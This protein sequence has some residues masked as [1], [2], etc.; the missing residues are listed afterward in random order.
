VT[1]VGFVTPDPTAVTRV[2][3][4]DLIAAP[5]ERSTKRTL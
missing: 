1:V 4:V 2:H 3:F 5:H